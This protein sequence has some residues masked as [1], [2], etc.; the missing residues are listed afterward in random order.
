VE[1]ASLRDLGCVGDRI[2][3]Y[4]LSRADILGLFGN[5]FDI[6]SA[7]AISEDLDPIDRPTDGIIAAKMIYIMQRQPSR[8]GS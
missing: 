6:I 4:Q 5:D 2:K 7:R 8:A 3:K 1:G